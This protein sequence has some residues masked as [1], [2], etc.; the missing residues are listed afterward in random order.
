VHPDESNTIC[1]DIDHT[2][3]VSEGLDTYSVAVPIDGA[4][5]ALREFRAKGWWVVLYTARHFNHWR[6]TTS[7]LEEHGFEYDQ[8]VF[9]KPPARFYVDDRA[10]RFEGDWGVV[11]E[12]VLSSGSVDRHSEVPTET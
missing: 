9:G 12:Q 3:C 10:I 5:E 11:S 7:W 8:L 2:L 4:K 6:V 1:V